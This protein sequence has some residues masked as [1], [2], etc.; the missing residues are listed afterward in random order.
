MV[1]PDECELLVRCFEEDRWALDQ[2]SA[3]SHWTTV[4]QGVKKAL[5]RHLPGLVERSTIKDLTIA[6]SRLIFEEHALICSYR[7][8]QLKTV[9][10]WRAARYTR[11]LV[12]A[13]TQPQ[14]DP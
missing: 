6:C 9:I 12:R 8:F 13:V 2:W 1:S 4:S 5:E 10:R 3:A 7:V 14:R 11:N